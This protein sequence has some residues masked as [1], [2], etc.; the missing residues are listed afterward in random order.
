MAEVKCVIPECTKI[1]T[2]LV[3]GMCPEHRAANRPPCAHEGCQE[4][5]RPKGPLCKKHHANDYAR[6]WALT[7]KG[8][9]GSRS[10]ERKNADKRKM[11]RAAHYRANK[12]LWKTKYRST[13]EERRAWMYGLTV[14]QQEA[15]RALQ[16]GFCAIC[17]TPLSEAKRRHANGECLDHC[18]ETRTARGYLCSI[19]NKALGFYEKHQRIAGLRIA[20]YEE[21]LANPP[22]RQVGA[23]TGPVRHRQSAWG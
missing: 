21:Y 22:A 17:P 2:Y 6:R 1:G 8:R 13:P 16:Q 12:H 5:A 10:R 7:D 23:P 3:N 18:H 14:E 20:Q 11:Q 15:L 4:P 19:C 9:E